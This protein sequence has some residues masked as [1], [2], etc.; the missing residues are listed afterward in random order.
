MGKTIFPEAW[1][2]APHRQSG[3]TQWNNQGCHNQSSLHRR[4]GDKGNRWV[5]W[6][7]QAYPTHQRGGHCQRPLRASHTQDLCAQVLASSGQPW[8]PPHPSSSLWSE[9]GR[10]SS[11]SGFDLCSKSCHSHL[12]QSASLSDQA[13]A[14]SLHR[15]C[16][17]YIT[18]GQIIWRLSNPDF[19]VPAM[20]S[21]EEPRAARFTET[22][23][24]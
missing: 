1:W 17:L 5:R 4:P 15:S 6:D 21:S 3:T 12:I 9:H 23:L 24:C 20:C 11:P 19:P 22:T 7:P 18:T 2:S 16:L 13:R 14:R 10:P 8:G